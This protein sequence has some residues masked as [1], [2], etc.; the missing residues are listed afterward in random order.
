MHGFS[1]PISRART[2]TTQLGNTTPTFILVSQTVGKLQILYEYILLFTQQ[3]HRTSPTVVFFPRHRTPHMYVS[4]PDRRRCH[5][6][7][8]RGF[9]PDFRLLGKSKELS[10]FPQAPIGHI[11][12]GAFV[13][14]LA[15]IVR[16]RHIG[17]RSRSLEGLASPGNRAREGTLPETEPSFPLYRPK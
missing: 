15:P 14:G 12:Y 2:T 7:I 13:A 10:F 17:K 9:P 11:S 6:F 1:H 3:H 4:A 5:L 16:I 8:I